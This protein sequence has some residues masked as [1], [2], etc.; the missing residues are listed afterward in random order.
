MQVRIGDLL[1]EFDQE[2]FDQCCAKIRVCIA[3]RQFD[4]ARQELDI[5]IVNL[6]P[7]SVTL[8]SP[9]W[10][11]TAVPYRVLA[12]LESDGYLTIRA[13]HNASDAELMKIPD[14]STT[15][16]GYIRRALAKALK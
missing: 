7:E 15:H 8:E 4:Y 3:R 13:V 14:I 2:S 16:L 1:E 9:I 12:N 6:V 5:F 10:A 11:L